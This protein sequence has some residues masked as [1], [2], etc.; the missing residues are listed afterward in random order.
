VG[1]AAMFMVGGGILTHGIPGAHDL[2]HHW[3]EAIH[4]IPAA[5]GVLAVLAPTLIDALFGVL[6]GA[7]VLV[8]VSAVG[9]AWSALRA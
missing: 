7:L 3:V 1:T 8:V 6:V 5:G 4:A 2:I 9:K